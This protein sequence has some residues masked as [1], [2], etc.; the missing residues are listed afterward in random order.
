MALLYLLSLRDLSL[1]GA[2]KSRRVIAL[3]PGEISALTEL[4]KV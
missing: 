4:P 3:A 2:R 1:Q